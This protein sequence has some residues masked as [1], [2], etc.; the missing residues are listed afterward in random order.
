M[1]RKLFIEAFGLG[2]DAS[3]GT[4]DDSGF[5]EALR[6]ALIER[7]LHEP[8]RLYLGELETR[9]YRF[10]AIGETEPEAMRGLQ[11]AW[12][13]H[14]QRTGSTLL[15]ASLSDQVTVSPHV[16]GARGLRDKADLLRGGS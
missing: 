9:N 15:W 14:A 3:N 4:G 6:T 8:Q 11:S 1:M 10:T 2:W 16:L 7:G 12:E 13:L 5:D